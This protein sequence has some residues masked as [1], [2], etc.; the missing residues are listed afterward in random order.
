[1]KEVPEA[2]SIISGI[3]ISRIGR[4][5]GVAPLEL[6]ADAARLAIANAGLTAADIDGISTM[7]DTPPKEAAVELGIDPGY[8]GGGFDTG[9]LLSPVMSAFLAVAEGRARHVLV[10][11]TVQMMGG[12]VQAPP[13]GAGPS[14]DE[15]ARIAEVMGDVGSLLAHHAYSAA[16][17]L[18][19][20]C[21][22]HMHLYGTT[23]EQLGAIALNARRNAA[24]NPLAVYRDPM[25][26]EDY[27]AARP[28]SSPFGRYDCD[29]PVDGSIAV[30]VS[31][32]DHAPQCPQPPVR[33]AAMGGAPAGGGWVNRSDY[34]RMAS[35]DAAREMWSRTDLTPADLDV[36]ELYDGFTFLTLAWLEALGI[37]GEGE[38]GPFVEEGA[39]IALDGEL[40]LNTYGG[41][42]SAGRLHG[43]WVLH[44]ACLQ[45]RGD[46]GDRQVA[47]DPEVAVVSAG[48]GPIA[49]CILLTR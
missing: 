25:T 15:A 7:G 29:V 6:T 47:G 34:P 18:A 30:V 48:G 35:T 40:P 39:R 22:R 14:T 1:M 28:V 9:G 26:M 32:A 38:S 46:A 31:A 21:N 16:N 44:E 42:L 3:G 37:C 5:L 13:G 49:G 41:Q 36:A 24:L 23:K 2:G 11:R 19:M 20:H 17:W 27:L 45:L 4:R 8:L 43:Y 12:T 10:Y 33:V